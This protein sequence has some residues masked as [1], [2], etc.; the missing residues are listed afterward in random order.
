MFPIQITVRDV[1]ALP[2]LEEQLHKRAEKLG[3]FNQR[4]VS[5]KV[6][7]EFQQKNQ[8]QGK[9]YNVRIDVVVPQK[10]IVVTRKYHEDIHIAIREAFTAV[11]RQLENYTDI[12]QGK[13]KSHHE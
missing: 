11:E 3:K 12:R 1:S 5:C 9:L 6:V 7:I 10:E 8:H 4:I 13:V 2:G